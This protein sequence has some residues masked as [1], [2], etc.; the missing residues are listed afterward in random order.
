MGKT[1]YIGDSHTRIE[2]IY[3]GGYAN[4]MPELFNAV[5]S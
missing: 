5:R 3:R 2:I 1:V 4:Y